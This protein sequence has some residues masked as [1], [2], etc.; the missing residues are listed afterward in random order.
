MMQ[1]FATCLL[2]FRPPGYEL[3]H[4]ESAPHVALAPRLCHPLTFSLCLML[5]QRP[6]TLL[7]SSALLPPTQGGTQLSSLVSSTCKHHL[8]GCH[9]SLI[10][11]VQSFQLRPHPSAYSTYPSL[12]SDTQTASPSLISPLHLIRKHS[13]EDN[14]SRIHSYTGGIQQGVCVPLGV[15][16]WRHFR[17]ITQSYKTFFTSFILILYIIFKNSTQKDIGLYT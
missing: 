6:I 17:L 16:Q 5:V 13:R 8:S 7:L 10:T 11:T 1:I 14:C 12:P 4:F 15:L 2:F 9:L 3:Y